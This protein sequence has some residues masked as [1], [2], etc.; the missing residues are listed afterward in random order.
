MSSEKLQFK[1]GISGT[2]WDKHPVYSVVLNDV[3]YAD[4]QSILNPSD[5]VFYVEFEAE[6]EEGPACLQV[7][8]ENKTWQDTIQNEDKTEIVK[9]MLLNI[10]DVEIDGINLGNLIH[11]AT[12][13]V[14]DDSTRPVLDNCVN[15]GWNGAWTLDFNSPFYVWLLE[16][17]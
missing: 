12:K 10:V 1:I 11:T 15:L 9:D 4:N 3:K 13:F 17:I 7:R 2:Y 16:N 6:L 5:E 14:G 8:L